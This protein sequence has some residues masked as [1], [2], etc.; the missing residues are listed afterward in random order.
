MRD[1][2]LAKWTD[3]GNRLVELAEAIPGNRYDFRPVD[4]VRTVADQLRHAAFWNEYARGK[5]RGESPDDAANELPASQFSTKPKI[6]DALRASVASVA[7]ELRRRERVTHAVAETMVTYIE[8][9]A[10]HYGQLVVYCRL[11]DIVPP[12]SRG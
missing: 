3:I 10:E 6:V 1:M 2:L 4:G 9:G 5:L 12:A 11:N 7:K 8:H